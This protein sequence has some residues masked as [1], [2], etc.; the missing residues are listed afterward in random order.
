MTNWKRLTI[1]NRDL[2]IDVN[3][4]HVL[5]MSRENERT[6]LFFGGGPNQSGKTRYIEV[7]E[8]PDEIHMAEH[9]RSR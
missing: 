3:M 6:T 4:D 9:L 1:D 5:Y 7:K 8:T 2:K